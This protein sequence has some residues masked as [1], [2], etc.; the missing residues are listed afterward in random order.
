M[1]T[2]KLYVGCKKE[3]EIAEKFLSADTF[4]SVELFDKNP[5]ESSGVTAEI[6]CY[7]NG[8]LKTTDLFWIGV[9]LADYHPYI[10]NI[11]VE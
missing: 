1:S 2:I 4:R 3:L 9:E 11:K 7:F 6:V 10:F 5:E 8:E